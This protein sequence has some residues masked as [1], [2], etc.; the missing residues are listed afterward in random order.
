[1]SLSSL[2]IAEGGKGQLS[3]ASSLE[4]TDSSGSQARAERH[5]QREERQAISEKE[6]PSDVEL[7]SEVK[8][9][10]VVE[11]NGRRFLQRKRTVKQEEPQ[12]WESGEYVIVERC[13]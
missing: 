10:G 9:I 8:I 6:D 1:M 11:R 4:T 12:K 3:A 2:Y 7:V 5:L 13:C